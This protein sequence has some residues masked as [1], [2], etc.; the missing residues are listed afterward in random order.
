MAQ[1]IR[2]TLALVACAAMVSCGGGGSRGIAPV[3]AADAL[4]A[5]CPGLAGTTVPASSIG[6]AS[7]NA[8]V[9]SATFVAAA[10]QGAS[11]TTTTPATPDYC[12][13]LGTIAPVDPAA[14]LI[15]FEVNLPTSWNRKAVQYGGGGYNGTLTTGLT[16][17][18]DANPDDPLPLT[19]GYATLG[20]DS[21]HQASAFAPNAIGQFGL[22][23][24]MLANYGFASY[25][26]VKDVAV[27]LMEAYYFHAPSKMY[28]FG[29]S[30]GGREGLTMAQRFPADYDG[31][32]SVV[33]VVQLSMLF[34]SY[35]PHVRPQFN[36]GWMN[37]AK[38][39]TMAKFVSD[40]C[41]SLDGL[42]DGVISNYLACPARV[43]LDALRC[44]GGA[45][46]GDSCLSDAQIAVVKSMHSPYTLPFAVSNG[47]TS[48]P[49]WP[50]YGNET[51]P[52]P[53]NPTWTRWVTGTAP[54]TTAVD[55]A[56]ASQ[57]WLYGAN[58]IRYFVTRNASFDPLAFD[59]AAY[60]ARLQQ[61]SAL[62]D[63][64]NPDLKAF[65]ARGGKLIMR[66]NTSDV[67]QSPQAGIDYFMAV[68]RTVGD[69][70]MESSARLYMS[71]GSTHS[72]PGASVTTGAAIP[73]S[74]DL[75]DPLDRWVSSGQA[76]AD[77]LVQTAKAP[78]PP[79]TTQ[80]ARPMCRYPSYPKYNGGDA[81]L[82]SSY[83]C[84]VSQP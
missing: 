46:A 17:L 7:G 64:N 40:T 77:S 38:T 19:R 14:Q 22:N 53:L 1:P 20:T 82:A 57:H 9:T 68:Q 80:S 61:V 28:Y 78:T 8:T 70:T 65:F 62:I 73:T 47:A 18:R 83:S 75:L 2:V 45:D 3:P 55:A 79:F 52:D 33:P 43:N 49:A 4:R 15:N 81:K 51:T 69:S 37:T 16:P 48:Y 13:V 12:K 34:Q 5:S 72:G 74:V 84:A 39:A 31:I 6:L 42:A 41:D 63:S 25:K 54:P 76:P 59:P 66:E 26:K 44:P 67:A 58:F 30:E 32:V 35:I 10:P 27:K 56:T 36:G 11:G 24:E 23:D 21:G 50:F 60:Q 71:P 29:G